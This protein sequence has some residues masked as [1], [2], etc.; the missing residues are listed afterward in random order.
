MRSPLILDV[1]SAIRV[2]VRW[3]GVA[4]GLMC[5]VAVGWGCGEVAAQTTQAPAAKSKNVAG[6]AGKGAAPSVE[7]TTQKIRTETVEYRTTPEGKLELHVFYPSDWK[8]SDTR[9]VMVFFFGGGWKGGSYRQFVPQAEYFA[10]R[11]LVT[12]CADYRIASIHKTTPD[13]CVEDA[14]SAIRYVRQNARKLGVDP[15]KVIASGGSAG[16]HL[17]AATSLLSGFDTTNRDVSCQPNTLV[18][19]NPALNLTGKGIKNAAG[20]DISESFSPTRFL[21]STTPPTLLFFGTGDAMLSQGEEYQAKAKGLGVACEL[22]T[23]ADQPHG[24]FN[25]K[26]WIEVTTHQADLFLTKLGYLSG[27]PTLKVA[28]DSPTLK[29]VVPVAKP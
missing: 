25:R 21:A 12:A 6:K 23:A 19:F 18:L 26:P 11:G 8:A 1:F 17:A 22:Y 20:E 4:V 29:A 15:N 10:S 7:L 5:A 13:K 24:F 14:K 16:G 28:A 3:S 9:P 27:P 2:C